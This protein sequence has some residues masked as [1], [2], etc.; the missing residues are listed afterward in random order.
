MVLNEA[1]ENLREQGFTNSYVDFS[2]RW[3]N[4]SA[5]YMSMLRASGRQPSVDTLARFV[6]NLKF[7]YDAFKNSPH[8]IIRLRADWI[9][10]ILTQMNKELLYRAGEN[11]VW[12]EQRVQ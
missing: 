4:K 5:R 1:Y 10:P 3:L 7:H 2:E 9:H 6:C 11:N 8:D 12:R